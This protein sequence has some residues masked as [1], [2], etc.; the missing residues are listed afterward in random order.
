[1]IGLGVL[2]CDGAFDEAIERYVRQHVRQ[3]LE[4]HEAM[5][6]GHVQRKDAARLTRNGAAYKLLVERGARRGA[7]VANLGDGWPIRRSII[8]QI[9]VD[10][11]D[12]E[13]E[14][15]FEA[16]M[17]W[18]AVA[19]LLRQQIEVESLEVSDVKDDAMTLGNR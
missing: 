18:R 3:R 13:R 10:G 4:V 9:S 17:Q 6:D 14:E 2:F 19:D 16:R 8:R 1:M 12:S 11:I 5:F 15:F 7:V